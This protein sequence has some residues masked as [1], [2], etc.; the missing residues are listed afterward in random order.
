GE[1]GLAQDRALYAGDAHTGGGRVAHYRGAAGLSPRALL[2]HRR[3]AYRHHAQAWLSRQIHPAAAE[4]AGGRVT[5]PGKTIG[6]PVV[7]MG[8]QGERP[9]SA[10]AASGHGLVAIASERQPGSF[11]AALRNPKVEAV[12]IATPNDAHRGPLIAAAHAGKH[13]LCEKP[14]ALTSKEG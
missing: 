5:M 4:A 6:W 10:I 11:E 9:A 2:A 7:G 1:E 13:V 3:R 14:L 12:A 8:Q